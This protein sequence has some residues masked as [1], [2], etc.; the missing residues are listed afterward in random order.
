MCFRGRQWDELVATGAA[1]HDFGQVR[2]G[3]PLTVRRARNQLRQ[4]L[5]DARPEV[6]VTRGYWPHA[7]SS[8]F[9]R[10][11]SDNVLIIGR[12]PADGGLRN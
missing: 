10:T 12:K 11:L 7:M 5:A 6:V 1:V 4:V 3:R 9:P 2:I 8:I